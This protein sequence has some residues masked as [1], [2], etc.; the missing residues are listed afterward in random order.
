MEG[1]CSAE[2]GKEKQSKNS[3]KWDMMKEEVATKKAKEFMARDG[4]SKDKGGQG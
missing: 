1:L 2:K 3:K 4:I